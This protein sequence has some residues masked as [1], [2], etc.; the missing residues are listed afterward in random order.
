MPASETSGESTAPDFLYSR[1]SGGQPGAAAV[2]LFPKVF[3]K[4]ESITEVHWYLG[5]F[6]DTFRV[7]FFSKSHMSKDVLLVPEVA[8]LII[9]QPWERLGQE[10]QGCVNVGRYG[11][12]GA[13]FLLAGMRPELT[14]MTSLR[15]PWLLVVGVNKQAAQQSWAFLRKTEFS[16]VSLGRWL[17]SGP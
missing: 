9:Q 15:P 4:G 10:A 5:L 7:L 17:I 12:S 3:Y 11:K 13:N 1:I 2:L 14:L 8:P 6:T 16:Y